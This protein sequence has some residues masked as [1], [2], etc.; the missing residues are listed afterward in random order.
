MKKLLLL[1]LVLLASVLTACQ[2]T[3]T[4]TTT[5]LTDT[6]TTASTS[7]TTTTT[8]KTY[9]SDDSVVNYEGSYCDTLE[10]D[11]V[12]IEN[13]L[14]SMTLAEKVGQMLQAE[15]N[16]ASAQDAR[17]YNLGSILSGG[18]SAP[19]N[20]TPYGWY[21]LYKGYQDAM[22]SSSSEIPIIYGLDAV[23]GDNNVYG[24]TMF[25]HN[26]GLGAANDPEL[27]ER[28]GIVTAREVR[29]TGMNYTFAPAVSLVQDIS[30]G[31]TYE[32]MSES[33]DLVSSLVG[34]YIEGLQTYCIG[35]SAKHYVAD[36][37]TDGGHD[38]GNASL[39]E[40][41]VRALHL[42]PYYDAIEA[43]VDTI[44]VSY[45][46][47]SGEK[48]HESEYWIQTVLKDE[49]GFEGFVISD[50]EAIHQLPGSFYDQLVASVN[51]G[52]DMLMEPWS[53]KSAIENI[54]L[55][56][57]QGDISETRI[58]DAVRRILT[59]KYKM[60]LFADDFY[61]ENTGDYYRIPSY[62]G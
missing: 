37:G 55:A 54:I 15:K 8:E 38:Q 36:G 7:T 14:S 49:M 27:M 22:R 1:G 31:R 11:T 57:Q 62:Q 19:S 47:I 53:W 30:W 13:M 3:T 5:S 10:V 28:I 39:T 59:I 9:L 58:D 51:A 26:I 52:I 16:G 56:V 61:D 33:A 2:T 32:S 12:F 40:E 35:A 20:N 4:T 43:G 18:G 42:K 50:Y 6:D 21:S 29:T 44:M 25:P 41:E 24:A 34:S 60:G 17:D 48:M 23:H 46:S 45:S